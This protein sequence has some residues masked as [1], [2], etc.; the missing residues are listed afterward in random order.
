MNLFRLW[1]LKRSCRTRMISKDFFECKM[2]KDIPR[3]CE[4]SLSMGE[5]FICNHA[6]RLTFASQKTV[7]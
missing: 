1:Q 5:S 6:N 2:K 7:D 3:F 4:Y